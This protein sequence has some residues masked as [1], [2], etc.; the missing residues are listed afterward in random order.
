MRLSKL[1]FVC[2]I[3]V[4]LGYL[5]EAVYGAPGPIVYRADPVT[6]LISIAVSAAL[7]TGQ[8]LLTR[9]LAPRQKPQQRGKLN[10]GLQLQDSDFD[11]FINEVFGG[12]PGDGLGGGVKLAGIIIDASEMRKVVTTSQ[13][14]TGGGGGKGGSGGGGGGNTQPVETT[15]YFMDLDVMVGRGPLVYHKIWFVTSAGLKL[16]YDVTPEFPATGVI[17]PDFPAEDPQDHFFLPDPLDTDG[18]PSLRFGLVPTPDAD[19]TID[20]EIVGSGYGGIRIYEGN[21][22]QLPDPLFEGINNALYGAPAGSIAY[23]GRSHVV[24]ENVDVSGGVPQILFL[25]E[26]KD[27]KTLDLILASRAE[28]VGILPEDLNFVEL[29]DVPVRGYVVDQEQA[30]RADMEE[31]GLIFDLNF[32]EDVDGTITGETQDYSIV[33]TIDED[34]IGA[35]VSGG[36]SGQNDGAPPETVS[37]KQREQTELPTQH[38][39]GYFDPNKNYDQNTATGF[40]Q[41]TNSEKRE[42]VRHNVVMTAAEAQLVADRDIQKAWAEPD[43]FTF[44]LFPKYAYLR[45]GQRILVP[46]DDELY[47]VKLTETSG[48]LPGPR[49]CSGVSQ[50]TVMVSSEIGAGDALTPRPANIPANSVATFID[51][52][53]LLSQQIAPGFLVAATPKDQTSGEW[54]SATVWVD[55]GDGF[56]RL[57]KVNAPAT[58]GRAVGVLPDV[59]GGWTEGDWDTVSE[60]TFDL[61]YG[62]MPSGTDDN[63]IPMVYGNE[64]IEFVDA[65]KESGFPNRWTVSRMHRRLKQTG[66]ASATHADEERVVMLDDAVEYVEVDVSE[67]DVPRTYKVTTNGIFVSQG[68]TE[69]A[70]IS[71]TWTGRTV[72]STAPVGGLPEHVPTVTEEPTVARADDFNWMVFTPAPAAYGTGTYRGE[73]RVRKA[74]ELA[75]ETIWAIPVAGFHAITRTPYAALISYRWVNSSQE[76]AGQGRGVSAWSPEADGPALGDD[77]GLPSP[78]DLPPPEFDPTDQLRPLPTEVQPYNEV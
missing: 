18:N 1:Q 78:L 77:T 5:L 68:V 58:M 63:P 52:P 74:D 14:S 37:I 13:Q 6:I 44:D 41:V 56:K 30:P 35:R 49:H 73:I 11:L 10:G 59:P 42:T 24:F 43:E 46:K 53:R 64:V 38:N 70:P 22:T 19:G 47:P 62:D 21:A 29:A 45:V 66:A 76:D 20:A 54:K 9:A 28:R 3:L 50:K 15:T 39:F 17:D 7:Y 33:A 2:L 67:R 26:N 55:K 75:V 32:F 48:S 23:R 69:A 60:G 51:I 8:Y 25:V 65:V 4:L 16:V 34:D 72:G 27:L 61:F 12:D 31:L 71:F 36:G 40:R 57:A